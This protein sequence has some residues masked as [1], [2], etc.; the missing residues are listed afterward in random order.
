MRPLF[1]V[2][3]DAQDITPLLQDRL[4][5]LQV[6]DRVALAAD[7]CEIKLDDRDS[8]IAFPRKGACL[9]LSLGWQGSGLTVMGHYTIDEIELTGPPR[10]VTLR[11]TSTAM[12]GTAKN[13]RSQAWEQ[14]T[15]SHIVQAIA[16]RQGWI[17]TCPIETLVTRA[18]QVGES[19]LNFLSRLARQ[20][21]ATATLK[22]GKL[23]V[24]PR[25]AGKQAS[26]GELPLASLTL[27]EVANF[28]LLFPNR[29]S[30]AK[31]L[32]KAHDSQTG[33]QVTIEIPNPE[34]PITSAGAVHAERHT[35]A[36]ASLA[37]AAAQAALARLNRETASGTLELRGRGDLVAEKFIKLSGFKTEADGVYLIE[38]VTNHFTQRSWTTSI[39][40]SAGQS[41][42]ANLG[43]PSKPQP[44]LLI[45][46]PEAPQ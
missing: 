35:Y 13:S 8:K 33:Q 6:I 2:I 15:L 30:V 17:A 26:G 3:A 38:S 40:I 10:T 27:H 18:D 41:G 36:N 9:T 14:V 12:A 23:L 46:I 29:T 16:A 22:A 39:E 45:E 19:D 42:K 1:Q 24:L 34:A 20:Y 4:L 5:S 37:T 44:P 31:V 43:Q 32:A 25:A 7:S 28:R 21:N 11:G